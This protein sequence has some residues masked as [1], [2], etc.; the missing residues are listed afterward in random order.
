MERASTRVRIRI[1]RARGSLHSYTWAGACTAECRSQRT[2]PI[3]RREAAGPGRNRLGVT[4]LPLQ[5][6]LYMAAEATQQRPVK[7]GG[8]L[9]HDTRAQPKLNG[10]ARTH[11]PHPHA[12]TPTRRKHKTPRWWYK[13]CWHSLVCSSCCRDSLALSLLLRGHHMP[14]PLLQHMPARVRCHCYCC[15]LA[16]CLRCYWPSMLCCAMRRTRLL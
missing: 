3:Q 6:R 13:I 16:C 8:P 4:L 15:T 12:N 2:M 9:A 5:A 7:S 1:Q 14:L 10:C 11:T